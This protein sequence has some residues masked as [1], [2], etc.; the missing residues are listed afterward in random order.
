MI[1]LADGIVV[2]DR[3]AYRESAAARA[4]HADGARESARPDVAPSVDSSVP[5]PD[6]E[7]VA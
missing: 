7:E 4:E 5:I 3:E 2:E 1:R 6:D